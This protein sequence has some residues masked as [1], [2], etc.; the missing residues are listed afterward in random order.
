MKISYIIFFTLIFCVLSS[1]TREDVKFTDYIV[2][3]YC[4]LKDDKNSTETV[5]GATVKIIYD[6]DTIV[7]T[8]SPRA[9]FKNL[10]RGKEIIIIISHPEYN[11]YLNKMEITEY[12]YGSFE[13]T[14][15]SE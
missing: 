3:T 14:P 8:T 2:S 4:T 1:F 13:L 12:S 11:T 9:V 5:S 6:N 7:K 10:E 15:K